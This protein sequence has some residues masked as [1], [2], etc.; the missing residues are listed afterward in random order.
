MQGS[1]LY[2]LLL[3]HWQTDSLSLSHLCSSTMLQNITLSHWQKERGDV[4]PH[5]IGSSKSYSQTQPQGVR[6]EQ[7]YHLPRAA[8]IAYLIVGRTGGGRCSMS[9]QKWVSKP[10]C[11][12]EKSRTLLPLTQ[13]GSCSHDNWLQDHSAFAALFLKHSARLSMHIINLQIPSELRT[14]FQNLSY[15]CRKSQKP[16]ERIGRCMFTIS[17]WSVPSSSFYLDVSTWCKWGHIWKLSCKG[18]SNL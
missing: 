15:H 2:L 12:A 7:S 6:R 17:Q 11:R 1:N 5:F 16:P 14:R 10:R 9:F 13:L 4:Y 8:R 18:V 3:L